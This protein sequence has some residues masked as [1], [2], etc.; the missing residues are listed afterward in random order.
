MTGHRVAL[1][2][3]STCDI[4]DRL[5]REY[6]I[7]VVPLMVLWGAQELR[8]RVDI[9][10][11]DFYERLAS[12]PVLPTTSQ[13]S[14]AAFAQA[15]HYAKENGAEEAIIFTI[16]S[17]MSSTYQSARQ[18]ESL[19]DIPV[20]VV[21]SRANSMSL[22]W[23]VLAAARAREAGGDDDAMITAADGVRE[24]LV[25]LLYV[26]TLEYLHRGGRISG[27]ARWVGTALQLKPQLFVD[28]RTGEIKLA[29]R[30]RTRS[31]ALE[32]LFQSFFQ[33][34]DVSQSL[35]VAVMHGNIPEEAQA[36]AARIQRE[37][38]PVEL[39]VALTSPV[40]GIHTG[41]GAI[42]LCGYSLDRDSDTTR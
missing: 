19:V 32:T 22:G 10:P 24:N 6:D 20:R 37:Y 8:D 41:P 25:T 42:A 14:P 4:P 39:F 15:V 16:S 5:L 23:Q 13:P 1:I 30:T 34:L 28:H 35:R 27:V 3:D 7:G 38:A 29:S 12:D 26:D 33:Q 21:D 2:T 9:Q 11:T 40:S 17:G 31:K 36:L 18:A